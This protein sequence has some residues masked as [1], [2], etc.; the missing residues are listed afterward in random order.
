MLSGGSSQFNTIRSEAQDKNNK[1]KKFKRN[2]THI[3]ISKR[4]NN[5]K[6]LGNIKKNINFNNNKNNKED[7]NINDS[8]DEQK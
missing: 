3:F 1:H 2:N 4:V 8:L 6:Y 5:K 7:K